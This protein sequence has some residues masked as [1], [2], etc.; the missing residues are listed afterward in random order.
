MR[1][2]NLSTYHNKPSEDLYYP[3]LRWYESEKDVFTMNKLIKFNRDLK[4]LHHEAQEEDFL[5]GKTRE[6][7]TE[8]WEEED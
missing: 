6:F 5:S 1:N 4:Q 3:P 8:N 7:L 2:E